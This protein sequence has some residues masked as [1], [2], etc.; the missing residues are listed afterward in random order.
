MMDIN[1]QPGGEISAIYLKRDLLKTTVLWLFRSV[2]IPLVENVKSGK[3][4]S[5][6]LLFV[7]FRILN[8]YMYQSMVRTR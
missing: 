1:F 2:K 4:V 7:S 6:C 8:I 3:R 5:R